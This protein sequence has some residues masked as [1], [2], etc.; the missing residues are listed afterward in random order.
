MMTDPWAG[1]PVDERSRTRAY[2][3]SENEKD[4][5]LALRLCKKYGLDYAEMRAVIMREMVEESARI[6]ARKAARPLLRTLI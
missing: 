4:R 6:A 5:D 3:N 1:V 2:I